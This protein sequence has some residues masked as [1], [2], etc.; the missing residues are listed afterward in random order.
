MCIGV[1]I[2]TGLCIDISGWLGPGT[3]LGQWHSHKSIDYFGVASKF[4]PLILMYSLHS[5]PLLHQE[6]F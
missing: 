6:K 1:A 2:S 4:E 3:S 5:Q